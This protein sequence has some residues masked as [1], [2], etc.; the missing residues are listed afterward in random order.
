LLIV[1]GTLWQDDGDLTRTGLIILATG[2]VI[3]RPWRALLARTAT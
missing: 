3:Y 1:V 2:A